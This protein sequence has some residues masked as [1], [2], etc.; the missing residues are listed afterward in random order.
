M[1]LIAEPELRGA[2]KFRT[3]FLKPDFGHG[4]CTPQTRIPPPAGEDVQNQPF[5][6]SAGVREKDTAL[7]RWVVIRWLR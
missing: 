1:R 5:S 7:A 2:G 4:F 3:P 6:N